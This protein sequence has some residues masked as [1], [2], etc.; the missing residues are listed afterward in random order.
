MPLLP[1][2][3]KTPEDKS[4]ESELALPDLIGK[5]KNIPSKGNIKAS[6]LFFHFACDK[7]FVMLRT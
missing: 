4:C 1:S 6:R 7:Y 5:N 2:S 3:E